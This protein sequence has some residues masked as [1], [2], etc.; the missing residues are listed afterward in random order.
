MQV[1]LQI[2]IELIKE[3]TYIDKKP[4]PSTNFELLLTNPL[5]QVLGL[6][7]NLARGKKRVKRIKYQNSLSITHLA[8][9]MLKK[10]WSP[11]EFL[12]PQVAYPSIGVMLT[13]AN[14]QPFNH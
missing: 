8:I 10:P 1:P 4:V 9:L 3:N 13:K 11:R 2:Y 14:N 12:S 7:S 5:F 6:K